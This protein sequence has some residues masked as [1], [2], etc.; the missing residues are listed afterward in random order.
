M[1]LDFG[2][3]IIWYEK[4]TPPTF[5]ATFFLLK[6]QKSKRYQQDDQWNWFENLWT[7]SQG[8]IEITLDL[9][10]W[11]WQSFD[12]NV[13]RRMNRRERDRH[14]QRG[15]EWRCAS[16]IT[17]G[18]YYFCRSPNCS[19]LPVGDGILLGSL[20]RLPDFVQKYKLDAEG[21]KPLPSAQNE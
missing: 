11:S 14:H 3:T 1:A 2:Q 4:S 20:K 6:A 17:G 16:R 9:L 7:E 19:G 10:R 8:T 15:R 5:S 13:G 12:F 18:R 21:R